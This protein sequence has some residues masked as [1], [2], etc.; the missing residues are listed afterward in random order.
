MCGFRKGKMQ[1]RT[2]NRLM[3]PEGREVVGLGE[4]GEGVQK[5]RRVVTE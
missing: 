3:I 2:E 1:N 4:K 5:A